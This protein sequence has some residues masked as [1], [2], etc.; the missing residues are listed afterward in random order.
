MRSRLRKAYVAAS[1]IDDLPG[2]LSTIMP[3]SEV[4]IKRNAAANKVHRVPAICPAKPHTIPVNAIVPC[5]AIIMIALARPR[6]EF[7]IARWP[8]THSSEPAKVQ[9]AP[10]NAIG[11]RQYTQCWTIAIAR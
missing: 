5:D 1:S 10:A 4:A 9:L 11:I 3:A 7:G 8:I 6:I 2:A